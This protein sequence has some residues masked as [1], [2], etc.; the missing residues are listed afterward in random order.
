M[1]A[2]YIIGVLL[3][4]VLLLAGCGRKEETQ[5]LEKVPLTIWCDERSLEII[6]DA[7]EEFGELHKEEADFDFSFA[8]ESEAS[9]RDT[10]LANPRA[11]ADLFFFADDQ[12]D[13]LIRGGALLEITEGKAEVTQAV[14]GEDSGASSAA[15]REG[16][17]YAYPVAAGNGYFLYYR[18][19][20][21]SEED[22]ASLD[23]ILA[24][25]REKNKKF[26][27][28]LPNGWYLY[29]FFKGAGLD[30]QFNDEEKR[31]ECN[32]NSTD[33]QYA[34]ADVAQAII[35]IAQDEGFVSLNDSDGFLTACGDGTVIAGVNGA[36]NLE[37]L[38]RLWEGDI[39]ATKLPTYTLNGD[40]VQM[41]S[42]TGYKLLGIKAYTL[43][44]EWCMKLA[45]YL[46]G[47]EVQLRRFEE[48]GEC[49]ANLEAASSPEVQASPAIK[50]LA[51]QSRFGF[52]QDVGD[53]YWTASE[54]LGTTLAAGNPDHIDL[55]SLLDR[56]VDAA[57]E[58]VN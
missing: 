19:S 51:E 44:P 50:A 10:V 49:P 4:G 46:T 45:E 33:G 40:Q 26:T 17:L 13:D 58:P 22:L 12:L 5:E 41:A 29:S 8:A 6:R 30:L 54:L 3:L 47:K 9:C 14:G 27:M 55:Q 48:I 21:F 39:S 20:C 36:W 23:Q 56:M 53:P 7:A 43:H 42:F 57:E 25:C 18:P 28:A 31:N 35:D 38:Q 34:G 15:M 24:V 11:A 37:K 16:K 52:R 1:K 2:K 32:W